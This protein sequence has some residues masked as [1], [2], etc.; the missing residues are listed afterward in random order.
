MWIRETRL[1]HAREQGMTIKNLQERTSKTVISH[2]LIFKAKWESMTFSWNKY[3]NIACS[4]LLVF[5]FCQFAVALLY[6]S[7]YL[8]IA[9]ES[10]FSL[11]IPLRSTS[12]FFDLRSVHVSITLLICQHGV[13]FSSQRRAVLWYLS[14]HNAVGPWETAS[15]VTLPIYS[16]DVI[17]NRVCGND[18]LITLKLQSQSLVKT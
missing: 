8:L 15:L 1:C 5:R 9:L 10:S 2:C 4:Q 16:G 3:K 12:M 11:K 18:L 17:G 7:L 6:Y 13:L 14:N